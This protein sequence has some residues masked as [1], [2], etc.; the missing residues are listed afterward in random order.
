MNCNRCYDI[1]V[2]DFVELMEKGKVMLLKGRFT[3][4][5]MKLICN[6]VI[7]S[8]QIP[9]EVKSLFGG[10]SDASLLAK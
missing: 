4:A 6:G 9:R 7:K 5:D 10:E 1:T 3:E 2:S 8:T